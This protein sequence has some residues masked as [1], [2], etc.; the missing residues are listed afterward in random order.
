M[1][2]ANAIIGLARATLVLPFFTLATVEL[3]DHS[4]GEMAFFG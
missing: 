1:S 4:D 3:G 2:Q